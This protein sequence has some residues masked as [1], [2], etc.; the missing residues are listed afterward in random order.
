MKKINL[1]F[2]GLCCI[3]GLS[4]CG[5][6]WVNLDKSKASTLNIQKA[7]S[8]CQFEKKRKEANRYLAGSHS[9]NKNRNLHMEKLHKK[10]Y[11]N[12]IQ[13]MKNEGLIKP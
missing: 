11:G 13:C 6:T 9:N 5:T 12:A 1:G 8:K 3:I 2:I 4:G 7:L 10:T